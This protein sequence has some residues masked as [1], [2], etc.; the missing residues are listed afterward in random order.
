MVRITFSYNLH[1]RFSLFVCIGATTLF[2]LLNIHHIIRLKHRDGFCHK[3]YLGIW[4]YDFDIYYSVIYTSITWTVIFIASVNLCV[5][6]YCDRARSNRLK[7]QQQQQQP[8]Q[9]QTGNNFFPNGR[10][11]RG[12]DNDRLELIHSTGN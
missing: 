5:S 6:V 11:S 2:L 12:I 10:N 1:K 8:Q 3:D 4:D 7:K 9:T